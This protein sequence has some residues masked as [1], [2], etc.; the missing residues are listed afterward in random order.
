MIRMP[1]SICNLRL[2]ICNFQFAI[3]Y[4]VR[5]DNASAAKP[6]CVG[7]RRMVSAFLTMALFAQ[8]AALCADDPPETVP[9]PSKTVPAQVPELLKEAAAAAREIGETG[10]AAYA[11]LEIAV[12]MADSD[13]AGAA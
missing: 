7:M 2:A 13:K 11:L 3:R 5:R 6:G 9:P 10:P 8:S 12:V 4:G 1:R